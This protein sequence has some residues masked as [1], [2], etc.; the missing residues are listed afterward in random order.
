[1][2]VLARPVIDEVGSSSAAP[3]TSPPVANGTAEAGDAAAGPAVVEAAAAG[4]PKPEAGADGAANAQAAPE[5]KPPTP[6]G[7][8]IHAN[9]L[10]QIWGLCMLLL[11]AL[12]IKWL[13]PGWKELLLGLLAGVA[14]PNTFAC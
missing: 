10:L 6:A 12:L 1:V 14:C 2:A 3:A 11:T 7:R 4:P 9:K 8:V 13:S 5:P